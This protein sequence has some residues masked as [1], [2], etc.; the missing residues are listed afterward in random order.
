MNFRRPFFRSLAI[1]FLLLAFV[2]PAQASGLQLAKNHQLWDE[3][4]IFLRFSNFSTPTD[5]LSHKM[6]P[7]QP[8]MKLRPLARLLTKR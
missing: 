3:G 1:G 8:V 7:V 4:P 5:I 6:V 2:I